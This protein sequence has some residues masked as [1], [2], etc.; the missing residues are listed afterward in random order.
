MDDVLAYVL[1]NR[2]QLL[3]RFISKSLLF[4]GSIQAINISCIGIVAV[5][6]NR[7]LLSD[8]S[9]FF[10]FLT[11]CI[12][13]VL[14]QNFTNLFQTPIWYCIT[15]SDQIQITSIIS[16]L[17]TAQADGYLWAIV[18]WRLVFLNAYPCRPPRGSRALQ[19]LLNHGFRSEAHTRMQHVG[20]LGE[21][22]DDSFSG[23]ST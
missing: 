10:F 9:Q 14:E 20:F 8:F 17:I 11:S 15:R 12:I 22:R 18:I 13:S 23:S 1:A 4:R 2:S 7:T 5:S 3:L 16:M 21:K 6:F 19:S